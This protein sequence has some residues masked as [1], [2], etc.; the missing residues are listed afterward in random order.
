MMDLSRGYS[1]VGAPSKA[2]N[3]VQRKIVAAYNVALQRWQASVAKFYQSIKGSPT[4]AEIRQLKQYKDLVRTLQYQFSTLSGAQSSTIYNGLTKA[5][6]E[7]YRVETEKLEQLINFKLTGKPDSERVNFSMSNPYT[8]LSLN[9]EIERNRI[10][11]SYD[12]TRDLNLAINK[13]WSPGQVINAVQG[14]LERQAGK[15]VQILH[16]GGNQVINESVDAAFSMAVDFDVG[17]GLEKYWIHR[18]GPSG[19]SRLDHVAM[20]GKAADPDGQF[21][22]PNGH[23]GPGPGQFGYPEDDI[24]CYCQQ[25][26]RLKSASSTNQQQT[27]KARATTSTGNT[28]AIKSKYA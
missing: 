10:V 7:S 16:T 23:R 20:D 27:Q 28:P 3:E 15:M 17:D 24:H 25:S 8:G 11:G 26:I 4:P 14:S 19:G 1:D 22:L 5:Y 6:K 12:I 9:D 2:I 13:N 18:P 21:T